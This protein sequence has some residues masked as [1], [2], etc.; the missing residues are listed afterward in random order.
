[1]LKHV[2]IIQ[3]TSKE[4]LHSWNSGAAHRNYMSPIC[5]DSKDAEK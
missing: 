1:M 5:E 3:A 4:R 2:A